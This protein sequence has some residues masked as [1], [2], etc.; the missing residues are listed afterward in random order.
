MRWPDGVIRTEVAAPR[1]SDTAGVS[2]QSP[3]RSLRAGPDSGLRHDAVEAALRQ[4]ALRQGL[5]LTIASSA[6][7]I[8]LLLTIVLSFR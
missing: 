6:V 7:M 3:F 5:W 1:P 4:R 2:R 8:V